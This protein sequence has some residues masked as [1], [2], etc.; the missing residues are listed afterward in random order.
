VVL[1]PPAQLDWLAPGTDK[2]SERLAAAVA[3]AST[4]FAYYPV[5]TYVNSPRNQ[6]ERCIVPLPAVAG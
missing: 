6:G 1:P 5:G 4:E 3:S 2:G